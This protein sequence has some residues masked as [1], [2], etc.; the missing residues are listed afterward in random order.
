MNMGLKMFCPYRVNL[1]CHILNGYAM[2]CP[3]RKFKACQ[4]PRPVGWLDLNDAKV[5]RVNFPM[6]EE[7]RL[8]DL[9]KA[10]AADAC[11]GNP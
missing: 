4:W 6:T 3:K 11:K 10:D 2:G 1:G 8:A 7:D 9:R 5:A